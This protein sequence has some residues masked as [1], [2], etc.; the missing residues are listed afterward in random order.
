VARA[1]IFSSPSRADSCERSGSGVPPA[2]QSGARSMAGSLASG[3]IF[4]TSGSSSGIVG[5]SLLEQ[6]HSGL[7]GYL[8]QTWFRIGER[9]LER[10]L[11]FLR[12]VRRGAFD[13]VARSDLRGL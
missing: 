6:G 12:A 4:K 9:F 1:R 10:G 8:D 5:S 11:D 3:V 7:D 13:P 2:T